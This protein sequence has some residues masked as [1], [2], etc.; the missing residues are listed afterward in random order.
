MQANVSEL[1]FRKVGLFRPATLIGSS[2]TP[3]VME[4]ISPVISTILPARF[5]EIH[6]WPLMHAGPAHAL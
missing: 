1:G 4:W 3:S 2:N 6:V 5:K